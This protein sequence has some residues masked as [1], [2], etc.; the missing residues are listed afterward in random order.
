MFDESIRTEDIIHARFAGNVA[1]EMNW[2]DALW[3]I[4]GL[5]DRL[6]REALEREALAD[7]MED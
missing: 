5:D 6:V 1:G 3:N 4:R 7:T 2:L